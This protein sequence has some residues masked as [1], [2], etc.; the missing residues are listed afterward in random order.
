M[1][2][3]NCGIIVCKYC[4]VKEGEYICTARKLLLHSGDDT[5]HFVC[6]TYEKRKGSGK[7]E[8]GEGR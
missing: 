3:I 8:G 7:K 4:I 5:N 2:F 6:R 1:P